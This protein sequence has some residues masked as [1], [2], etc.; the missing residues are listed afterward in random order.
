MISYRITFRPV[1][2]PGLS[3]RGWKEVLRNS[4]RAAA[5]YWHAEILPLHFK[6]AARGKYGYQPRKDRYQKQKI[7]AL[8]KGKAVDTVDL[9]YSGQA[10]DS[11]LK[12]PRI[13]AYPTRARV[14]LLVPPYINM[15]PNRA[16]GNPRP[17]LGEEM[18][19]VVY[20]ESR[21]LAE[22]ALRSIGMQTWGVT[23]ILQ[24]AGRAKKVSSY[25]TQTKSS[26]NA[27]LQS[28]VV[29]CE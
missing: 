4:L 28:S 20:G 15:R 23:T 8:R 13:R 17:A 7:N 29:I 10:R 11:A 2:P 26:W 3:T 18:T 27:D 16:K 6:R 19:R 1:I 12:P 22:A 21:E 5:E 25:S 9:V 24:T 14:D